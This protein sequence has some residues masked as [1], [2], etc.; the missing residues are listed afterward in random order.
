MML[1]QMLKVLCVLLPG[2]AL[3]KG[4][5]SM[6]F[7]EA[8][9][10]QEI[11]KLAQM[12]LDIAHVRKVA[13]KNNN[14]DE[15]TFRVEAVLSSKDKQKLDGAGVKWQLAPQQAQF[16]TSLNRQS[17][18]TNYYSFDEPEVG[19]KDTLIRTAMEYPHLVTL[20][21]IGESVQGRP[22]I[23]VKLSKK[24]W[25]DW[26]FKP[27][28]QLE[29]MD[30][31][32]V[33]MESSTEGFGSFHHRKPEVLYVSTHHAREWVAAYQGMRLIE[34]FTE[35]YGVDD[36]VTNLLDTTAIWIVPIANPDGY[37]Y[38]FTD[39]RLWRKNL[40]D[41][42][43]D[44]EITS[45]DGVDLNRNFAS[46]W[47]LDDEG[48]SP[49]FADGTYRG[50]EPES[51]PETKHL[52][53]FIKRHRFKFVL[54]YHTYSDLIL[55]PWGWQVQ[56]PSFDD[57][58]FVAQAGTDE[59]PAIFD[60]L[61]NVGYDPGV[62]ADLY[63]TNGEFTDWVYDG[64]GIPAY[65]VELTAGEDADGNFYGFEF[66][67]D[68]TMLETVF[69]DNLEFALAMAESAHDPANPVSPVDIPA[70]DVYHE[71]IKSSWGE[72]QQID[73][74][75]RKWLGRHARLYYQID[76]GRIKKTRFRKQTGNAYNT[77]AGTY[78]S[79]YV[80]K[81]RN[82]SEGSKVTYWVKTWT[83]EYGPYEYEVKSATGAEVLVVAAEDYTGNYPVY[84][85][86]TAPNYLNF[87][88]DALDGAGYS[89]DVWDV[90]AMTAAPDAREVLSHYDAVIW[91]TGDDYA[92]T[93]PDFDVHQNMK[94][95]VRDY[96]NYNDGNIMATGQDLSLL[97]TI[98]GF[99]PDDFFQYYMGSFIH[100][101]G[102]GVD[103]ASEPF[104]VV[105]SEG[106]P[107]MDGLH[108]TLNG[109]DS[110]NNQHAND[111]FLVT[112]DFL[113]TYDQKLAAQYDRPNGPFDPTSGEYYIYSQ[114]A[115][116]SFKRL[117]GT[118]TLPADNP[119]LTFP[120]SYDIESDWDYGFVEI[121]VAGS[122]AWT[123]LPDQNGHTATATGDSCA[124]GWVDAI[125][126]HLANYMDADCNPVGSTGEWHA[127]TG[128][129]GGWQTMSFDL[130]AY[131]GE[132]VELYISYASDWGTQGLGMFL[133]DVTLGN[134]TED[135][136]T[137]FGNWQPSEPAGTGN[138]NDFDR[139]AGTG[140][141]EG[142]V[143]RG[144]QTLYFGFGLEGVDGY[145]NRV[146]LIER[147][148]G[149]FGL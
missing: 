42:D 86:N 81:I 111:S 59:N 117:G 5:L 129:S 90:D 142:P 149:Y 138:A 27:K 22:L 137:G 113:D 132:T 33:N 98:Y 76:D 3:A 118:F 107:V 29:D 12:N 114:M 71:P 55:Y 88:T 62:G 145:A 124:S 13:G 41:N 31:E 100:V 143:V 139:I 136:E 67:D 43:N 105:G 11:K 26:F 7:I 19:S 99:Y 16:N 8:N 18:E 24:W 2:V 85:N 119:V 82:Q 37:E 9:S 34:Y 4:D 140:F 141:R 78:Y 53:R 80:A 58:I 48:S 44:G 108:L 36:R 56:T 102:A 40:A 94:L 95:A 92:P 130:S 20:K 63:T 68:K 109:G 64:L 106:D 70:Q 96:L 115:D 101:E 10:L 91:Y 126:G 14:L 49:I 110:A 54:S 1:R 39:E 60:S 6:A 45:Q 123:T 89:Y 93:T 25:W 116:R 21:K 17:N 144:D 51:E 148:M 77:E 28:G 87:Y 52:V 134:T 135:F 127:F 128:N 131:A 133:D 50:P 74:L 15:V 30:D 75:A 79:R 84:D 72:K 46:H 61:N 121:S 104:A 120:T 38:T 73:I 83:G 97:S 65:T 147:A 69:N 112:S 57:P 66:P 32:F 125:H 47:G 35:N 122:N 103:T 146:T 23:A